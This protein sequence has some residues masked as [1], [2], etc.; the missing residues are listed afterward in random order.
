MGL[1]S[2]VSSRT[3]RLIAQ[4]LMMKKTSKNVKTAIKT[5]LYEATDHQLDATELRGKLIK[6]GFTIT[7]INVKLADLRKTGEILLIGG[8]YQCN[9][10]VNNNRKCVNRS[11]NVNEPSLKSEICFGFPKYSDVTITNKL[12][13][14]SSRTQTYQRNGVPL[15]VMLG[16]VNS[17]SKCS[18]NS[19]TVMESQ[20]KFSK[21][22]TE[23]A[24]LSPSL[25]KLMINSSTINRKYD[26]S[27]EILKK[28]KKK[29][30]KPI[31]VKK[32]SEKLSKQEIYQHNL[33]KTFM[34]NGFDALLKN[35]QDQVSQ[36]KIK[37][38]QADFEWS[39]YFN[40][41]QNQIRDIV[42]DYIIS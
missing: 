17:F 13:N 20:N 1:I 11:D 28:V 19:A 33:L 21:E 32:Y 25:S 10:E 40:H 24:Q 38:Y 31:L 2:R 34:E 12:Y 5:V 6:K 37:R 16:C 36:T 18:K 35:Y 23:K 22:F 42:K 27:A 30:N 15:N 39:L 9:T 3:Y 41:N 26:S 4:S 29:I 8:I 14:N 7:T